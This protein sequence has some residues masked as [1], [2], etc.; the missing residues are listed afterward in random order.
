LKRAYYYCPQ[1]HAGHCPWDALLRLTTGDLTPA[2][3]ELVSLAGTL[4]SF[5]EAADKVLPR[6]AGL[7]LAE[8]TA[9]RTTEAAGQRLHQKRVA[10]VTFGVARDWP[11]PTDAQGRTCA[12]VSVDATGVGMQGEKGAAAEGR[13]AYVGLVYCPGAE[14]EPARE[15][16]LAGL[17]E[18]AELGGQMRRQGAQVGM[19]RAEVWVA[20]TDLWG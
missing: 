1:C 14:K 9:E 10:G 2:A 5:A 15:R 8:S 17:Y 3:E 4:T 18:L 19:D 13:M 6:M 11:W 12:Y 16:A 20:L 7:R